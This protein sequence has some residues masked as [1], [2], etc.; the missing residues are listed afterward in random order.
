M[1]L[2]Q[3]LQ[4][5]G[6]DFASLTQNCYH[7]WRPKMR[8][9][10]IVWQE[11]AEGDDFAANNVKAERMISGSVHY[12]T[13]KEYDPLADNIEKLLQER[14]HAWSLESVQ[15]EEETNLIHHEWSW[16]AAIRNWGAV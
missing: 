3:T 8:P 16:Q 13:Q 2:Q 1:T 10:F 5:I 9:P 7:Y 15:Y 11:D 14:S 4:Q 6:D 12:F